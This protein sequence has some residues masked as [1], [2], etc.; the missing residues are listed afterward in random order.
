MRAI[1]DIHAGSE[2]CFPIESSLSPAITD[3]VWLKGFDSYVDQHL[4][5]R[6]RQ[7]YWA[8]AFKKFT[9]TEPNSEEEMAIET[10]FIIYEKGPDRRFAVFEDEGATGYLYL[11]DSKEKKVTRHLHLYNRSKD[12]AVSREAVKVLWAAGH[13]KCG[14]LIWGEM[15]G[16]IDLESGKEGRV[17]MENRHTPGIGDQKWL[18]GF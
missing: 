3:P 2:I 5:I 16:I 17:W 10:N 8:D 9:E 12:L 6:T 15:R 7:R 4:L 14:V 18:E 11:Y 1:L 13:A